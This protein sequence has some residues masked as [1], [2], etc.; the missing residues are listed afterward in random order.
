M[1]GEH[2]T[3]EPCCAQQS[4]QPSQETKQCVVSNETKTSFLNEYEDD[5]I[6]VQEIPDE[7]CVVTIEKKEVICTGQSLLDKQSLVAI[8]KIEEE[9]SSGQSLQFPQGME[10]QEEEEIS[11]GQSLLDQQGV[12]AIENQ[13]EPDV[14]SDI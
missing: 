11:S 1:F 13:E 4:I 6:Y 9:I 12:V 10:D 7:Q 8:D 14:C 2:S 5:V 3:D